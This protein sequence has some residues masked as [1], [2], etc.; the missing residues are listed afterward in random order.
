[1]G[2]TSI[3]G[4][5]GKETSVFTLALG[6]ERIELLP[7]RNW[8]QLD[9]FKWRVRGKL[10]G[11]PAG[12]EIT[13]DHV[14]LAGETISIN[15]ADGCS[16]LERLFNEWL[17]LEQATLDLARRKAQAKPAAALSSSS[18]AALQPLRFHVE[19]DKEAQVHVRSCRGKEVEATIGLNLAGFNSLI[20]QGLMRKPH[21]LKT[22]ALHNWVEIDG[23]LFSFEKG[24]N[25][26]AQLEKALNEGYLPASDLGAGKDIVVLSNSASSTGF[27]LQFPVQ[28]GGVAERR[29]RHLN[30][31]TLEILQDPV[32]CGL[33]QPGI[34]VKLSRPTL[35]FKQKTSDG[36]ERYLEKIP[37]NVVRVTNED[38]E[39]KLIDLSQPVNYMH[40]EPSELTAIFSH[41]V[42]NRHGSVAAPAKPLSPGATPHLEQGPGNAAPAVGPKSVAEADSVGD[43]QRRLTELAVQEGT[44]LSEAEPAES[45]PPISRASAPEQTPARNQ[46][47]PIPPVPAPPPAVNL[48][49]PPL[50]PRPVDPGVE[51]EEPPNQW[52]AT[53]LT[54][55]HIRHEWFAWLIYSR[56][57]EK[58]GT[59]RQGTM[60]LGKCWAIPLGETKD[61]AAPEFRGVFL[62]EKGGFGFIDRGHM[63]RFNK[64][65]AFI[66]TQESALEG[67]GIDLVAVGMILST[68]MVVFIVG[69]KFR[70]RFGVPET[71]VAQAIK[72]LA[73][74]GARIWTVPEA[75]ASPEAMDIVWTVPIEQEDAANPQ[76]EESTR[77][78]E[79]VPANET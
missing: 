54:R 75:L 55:Q 56:M 40:L 12:L 5:E 1:V 28:V 76:V 26:S 29:K 47:V 10:P 58:L 69:D 18:L 7:L 77:T 34:V 27:D 44:G 38:G 70:S 62:T 46:P 2:K 15:D 3:P 51:E 43:L 20:T 42:I 49:A 79:P 68:Q 30:E 52:L 61:P 24:R 6:E 9:I 35:I 78:V 50:T 17:A 11:T 21:S 33:L 39:E 66:G 72:Q 19:M 65:V 25:D 71:T 53:V 13:A 31:E 14:K 36:G 74:Y 23:V 45:A 67:I 60:G 37:A 73:E 57:A 22:G 64:G 32:H 59:S 63:A 48:E 4:P 8:G 41:P 16:H